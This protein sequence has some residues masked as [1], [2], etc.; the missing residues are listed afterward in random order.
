MGSIPT[1]G[2]I[3]KQTTYA[4]IDSARSKAIQ[5]LWCTGGAPARRYG[6]TALHTVRLPDSGALRTLGMRI[7]LR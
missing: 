4:N 6:P 7:G 2:T 3:Q 1:S 5:V